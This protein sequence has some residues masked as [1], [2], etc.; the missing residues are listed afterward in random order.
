MKKWSAI[1]AGAENWIRAQIARAF[2]GGFLGL[3]GA[4]K[5]WIE[6]GSSIF[7][8]VG[9]LLKWLT[10]NPV[11]RVPIAWEAKDCFDSAASDALPLGPTSGVTS[12]LGWKLIGEDS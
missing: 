9:S 1:G 12:R 5:L 2:I 11:H 6:R 7:R 8:V 3:Y 10:S 4:F